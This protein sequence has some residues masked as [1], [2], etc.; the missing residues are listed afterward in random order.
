MCNKIK[1]KDKLSAMFALSQCRRVGK[2]KSN[3]DECAY[4]FCKECNAYHLTCK[5][6]WVC[7]NT[8]KMF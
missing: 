5:R 1:Y 8:L 6:R 7:L 3:R 4:Y 2:R